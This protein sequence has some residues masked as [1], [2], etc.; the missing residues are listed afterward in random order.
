MP[1]IFKYQAKNAN[2][3]IFFSNCISKT[4]D[5]VFNPFIVVLIQGLH[6]GYS[7]ETF[8]SNRIHNI[9]L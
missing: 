5:T 4:I 8:E 3:V 9:W 6:G 1:I 2:M 7:N